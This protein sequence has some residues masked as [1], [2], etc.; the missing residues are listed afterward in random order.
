METADRVKS[1]FYQWIQ[2]D[3]NRELDSD[4]HLLRQ[5]K[6]TM[7]ILSCQY[8]DS[9]SHHERTD[10]L[11]SLSRKFL[12]NNNNVEGQK[13]NEKDEQ[14]WQKFSD[15][16]FVSPVDPGYLERFFTEESIRARKNFNTRLLRSEVK[17]ACEPYLGSL[18]RSKGKVL[19][20]TANIGKFVIITEI[21][22]GGWSQLRYLH[23]VQ[24]DDGTS[25]S[26]APIIMTDFLRWLGLGETAWEF[27]TDEDIPDVAVVMGHLCQHF[28]EGI[29]PLLQSL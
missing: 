22:L 16:I 18:E 29:K 19:S 27:M 13:P 20:Y 2:K 7:G 6:G 21:D 28:M 1:G 23:S 11:I 14:R 15:A 17:N 4:L 10:T 3:M 12:K 25:T 9:L 24:Y 26:R 5:V 8:F